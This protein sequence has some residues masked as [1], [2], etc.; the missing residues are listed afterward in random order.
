MKKIKNF[1]LIEL[2]VVIA[3]IAILAGM[4]LP[5]LNKARA[6]AQTTACSNNLKQIGLAFTLYSSDHND[7][8][9]AGKNKN[10]DG[11]VNWMNLLS[12]YGVSYPI[13]VGI[14][15]PSPHICPA[16][17]RPVKGS[18]TDYRYTHYLAN[19]Y[20]FGRYDKNDNQGYQHKLSTYKNPNS[21]KSCV[22]NSYLPEYLTSMAGQARFRHNG[23]DPREYSTYNGTILSEQG[24]TNVLFLGGHVQLMSPR[25]YC[26]G[27]SWGSGNDLIKLNDKTSIS[28]L[29]GHLLKQ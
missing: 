1:T 28:G 25:K 27:G 24:R 15:K 26:P 22:D 29:P 20:V 18:D 13:P 3:I 5:A 6:R 17:P 12:K 14:K 7:W 11:E 16:E 8:L 19:V 4:L 9:P 10:Q 2:L 21:V 23:S